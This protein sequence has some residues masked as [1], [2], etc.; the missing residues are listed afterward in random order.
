MSQII[1]KL[2][3]QHTGWSPPAFLMVKL[4]ILECIIHSKGKSYFVK[5]FN[6][7]RVPP[8]GYDVKRIYFGL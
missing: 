1:S 4:K 8:L 7:V 3:T 2:P 6:Y 5:Y